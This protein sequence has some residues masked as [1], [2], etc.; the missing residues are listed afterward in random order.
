MPSR[1]EPCGQGQLIAMRYGTPPVVRRIGGLA[2]TVI[3]AD[4]DPRAGT[5]FVFG[6]AEPGA[7]VDAVRRALAAMAEPE[8]FR[9]IQAQGMARDHSWTVPARQYEVAYQR[10]LSRG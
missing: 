9:R 1:F 2:D 10:A 5:G 8:R 7:L 6:P 4:A 3:D